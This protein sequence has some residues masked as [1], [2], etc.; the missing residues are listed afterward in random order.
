L[1]GVGPALTEAYGSV[2]RHPDDAD[3]MVWSLAIA[4][5]AAEVAAQAARGDAGPSDLLIQR[6]PSSSADQ[7]LHRQPV[8]GPVYSSNRT[9]RKTVGE[10][11]KAPTSRMFFRNKFVRT[12][13]FVAEQMAGVR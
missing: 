12:G 5:G 13:S 4:A 9:S 2:V 3:G 1:Y 10:T 7:A 6:A 11:A 8:S